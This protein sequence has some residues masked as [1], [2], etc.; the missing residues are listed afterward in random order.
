MKKL[1]IA[2][3]V[4]LL[5]IQVQSQTPDFVS[6]TII[7]SGPSNTVPYYYGTDGTRAQELYPASVFT[8]INGSRYIKSIFMVPNVSGPW[9]Y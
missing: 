5:C 1:L 3:L 7:P 8:A 4:S 2:L 6:Q 9:T